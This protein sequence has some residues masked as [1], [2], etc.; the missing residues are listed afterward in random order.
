MAATV[1]A[2]MGGAAY[3]ASAEI[4][5]AGPDLAAANPELEVMRSGA[6]PAIGPTGN[7][8]CA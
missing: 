4:A 7:R 1:T 8:S 5:S 3:R 2:L 6:F